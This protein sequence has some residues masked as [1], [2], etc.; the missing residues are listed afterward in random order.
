MVHIHDTHMWHKH[1]TRYIYGTLMYGIHTW[2]TC[3]A[4]TACTC[5]AH[6]YMAHAHTA[7]TLDSQATEAA[8][9]ALAVLLNKPI[10]KHTP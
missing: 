4:Y 8:G 6:T 5:M 9:A 7:H 10:S 3:H 1:H 2:H